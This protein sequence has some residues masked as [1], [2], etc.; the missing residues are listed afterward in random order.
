MIKNLILILGIMVCAITGAALDFGISG[1]LPDSFGNDII[2]PENTADLV[3]PASGI[4]DSTQLYAELRLHMRDT[5]NLLWHALTPYQ[6]TNLKK[7]LEIYKKYKPA[8]IKPVDVPSGIR[9]IAQA[10]VPSNEAERRIL[11]KNLEF[12][13]SN[14][15]NAVLFRLDDLNTMDRAIETVR[16]IRSMGLAV[17][18]FYSNGYYIHGVSFPDPDQ[19]RTA[20]RKIAP[21]LSGWLLGRGRTSVHL[22]TQ[23]PA[24]MQF[25]CC[26]LRSGNPKIL[27]VGELYYGYNYVRRHD[28]A[29]YWTYNDHPGTSAV[30]I[31]N[32]GFL[33]V[34]PRTVIRKASGKAVFAVIAG[35]KKEYLRMQISFERQLE[36]KKKLEKAY[37]AAGAAGTI[38][39]HTDGN[40]ISRRSDRS[41]INNNLSQTIYSEVYGY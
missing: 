3:D 6:R 30:A 19:L 26:A 8:E 20:L 23:D 4:E 24:Y 27:L 25:V 1:T 32:R 31:H 37:I 12:Y 10:E 9:M 17:W 34:D 38:T 15:Y 2:I 5:D 21:E 7:W 16:M 40:E 36:I 39:E 41:T 13:K 14:G 18:G 22:F 11:Q 35:P 29:L 33:G 28:T